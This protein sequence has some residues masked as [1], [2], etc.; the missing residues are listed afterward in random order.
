MKK[1][2]S[3][4]LVLTFILTWGSWW[5]LAYFTSNNIIALDGLW[6]FILLIIG[7][8]SPTVMAFV[9]T[10]ISKKEKSKDFN[11]RAFKFN[12]KPFYYAYAFAI[13]L[14]IALSGRL[15]KFITDGNFDFN[16]T[17]NIILLLIPAFISS[18]FLG[19][20]EEIG[21]RNVLQ[22]DMQ[23]KI[24][25]VV[26]NLIIS[27]IWALWHLPSFYI[28]GTGHYQNSFLVFLISCIGYGSFL[29]FLY[30]KTRSGVAVVI[31]HAMIN[32]GGALEIAIPLSDT[33]TYLYK[34]IIMI[35]VGTVLLLKTK[36]YKA[37]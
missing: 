10:A 6:G 36:N 7:G 25:P 35:I 27:I 31:F 15:I 2:I 3:L 14:L 8:S 29:T 1:R 22:E 30:L 33:N 21:W 11:K 24:N 5:T 13:P 12:I 28:V 23:A 37:T 16:L 26:M 18:V 9:S 32:T 34:S 20:L 19:G 17:P 4:F